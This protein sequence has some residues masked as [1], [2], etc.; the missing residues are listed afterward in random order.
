MT[1]QNLT[2]FLVCFANYWMG[3]LMGRRSA[4]RSN[5]VTEPT[6]HIVIDGL[7][8]PN[9]AD[10][11]WELTGGCFK[12]LTLSDN[13]TKITI[14]H[15]G[16]MEINELSVPPSEEIKWYTKSVTRAYQQRKLQ[17]ITPKPSAPTT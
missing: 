3:Y 8:L 7:Q 5:I 13:T 15:F 2:I 1:L 16:D 4:N 9:P 10:P 6:D 17:E 14:N 12:K 11:R